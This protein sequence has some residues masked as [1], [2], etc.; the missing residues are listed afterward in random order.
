[1]SSCMLFLKDRLGG[2][3]FNL[4]SVTYCKRGKNILIFQPQH[5]TELIKKSQ[6]STESHLTCLSVFLG[7]PFF[8]PDSISS[9]CHLWISQEGVISVAVILLGSDTHH[10]PALTVLHFNSESR[11]PVTISPCIK[12]Y[13]LNIYISLVFTLCCWIMWWGSILLETCKTLWVKF[14]GNLSL[15]I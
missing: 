14:E 9:L 10:H 15:V 2:R 1:M 5:C 12:Y 8:L 3:G 6:L 7:L 11:M 13:I 4:Y